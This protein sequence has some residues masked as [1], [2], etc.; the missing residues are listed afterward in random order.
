MKQSAGENRRKI[1]AAAAGLGR[2][3]AGTD[4]F[5]EYSE[6]R[7]AFESDAEVNRLIEDY[8]RTM[9]QLHTRSKQGEPPGNLS[10]ELRKLSDQLDSNEIIHRYRVAANA[11]RDRLRESNDALSKLL[12]TNFAKNAA[13]DEPCC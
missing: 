7:K 6:A 13:S 5:R 4:E 8:N 12:G 2:A 3:L 1:E 11:W 10:D 9:Q